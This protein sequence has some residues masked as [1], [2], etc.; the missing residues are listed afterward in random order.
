MF[1]ME[2]K[3]AQSCSMWTGVWMAILHWHSAVHHIRRQQSV[4]SYILT[5]TE[6][7]GTDVT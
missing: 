2:E 6:L 1:E 7:S 4:S 3:A 5:P